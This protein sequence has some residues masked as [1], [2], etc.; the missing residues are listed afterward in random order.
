MTDHRDRKI[1]VIVITGFLGS[2]KTT[3]LNHIVHQ[4]DMKATAVIV[5]EF[6]EI[7]I[8][9]LLVET[10]EENMIEINNGCICCTVRGDLAD[11]LGS[12]SMWLDTGHVPQVDRVIVETT[13]LADPAPIMHT[14]MTDEDLLNR[15]R[16]ESVITV[17]D[18]IAGASSIDR[19]SEAM[20]QAAIADHLVISKGDL[21]DSHSSPAALEAL[22][23]RLRQVNPRAALHE[24]VNGAIDMS[25]L[26]VKASD[27]AEA[28][29]HDFS[30]WVA[31]AESSCDDPD[32]HDH[33]HAHGH[34]HAHQHTH[35][36][37]GITS[38]VVR[39][40]KPVDQKAFNDFLQE[41]VIEFGEYLLRMKGILNVAGTPEKP[42]VIH[43]VQHVMFPVTW[44]E[45]WPDD[46]RESKLVFITQGLD[47]R[48]IQD[49]IAG[50]FGRAA[51]PVS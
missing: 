8:D 7:G 25:I 9:H 6:G 17:V 33:D 13:G 36:E 43:G 22:R 32:C 39:L 23:K 10:S 24:A 47:R 16:L 14:L 31:A 19:F 28:A 5:N 12:L 45:G 29:F 21:V 50:K 1:P 41:L 51:Q 30:D 49:R 18:G 4:P 20:K 11:K 27:D 40:D 46:S 34:G 38:F 26:D 44:L 35:D 3:I 48:V 37:G 42:A 15:Y 2:G